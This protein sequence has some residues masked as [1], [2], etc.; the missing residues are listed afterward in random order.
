MGS[1]LR[2]ELSTNPIL[3]VK[4]MLTCSLVKRLANFSELRFDLVPIKKGVEPI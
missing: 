4:N 3:D 1:G 2:I